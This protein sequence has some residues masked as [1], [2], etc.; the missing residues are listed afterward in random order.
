MSR[1]AALAYI[2]SVNAGEPR[3]IRKNDSEFVLRRG[4]GPKR[5]VRNGKVCPAC[6]ME[7]SL[8]GKCECNSIG[9]N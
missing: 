9:F 4:N 7:R 5:E 6:G 1:K 2:S 3:V 8:A